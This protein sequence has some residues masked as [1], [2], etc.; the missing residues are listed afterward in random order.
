MSQFDKEE[1]FEEE[2]PKKQTVKRKLPAEQIELA[3]EAKVLESVPSME[4]GKKH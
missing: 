2:L 4:R 1:I 3:P